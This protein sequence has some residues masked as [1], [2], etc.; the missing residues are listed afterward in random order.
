[1]LVELLIR[2]MA[3]IE[4]STLSGTSPGFPY[5]TVTLPLN[6][7]D[8]TRFTAQNSNSTN[9]QNT[10]GL[11]SVSGEALARIRIPPGSTEL[12]GLTMHHAFILL[13]AKNYASNAVE[14]LITP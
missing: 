6:I 10:R 1:M 13:D 3:L 11:L 5:G 9:L 4:E 12:V 14:L 8:Y 2:K 7:D